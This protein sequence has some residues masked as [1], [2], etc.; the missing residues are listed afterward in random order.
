MQPGAG[1]G[2]GALQRRPL[3]R[4][5]FLADVVE[6]RRRILGLGGADGDGNRLQILQLVLAGEIAS[7]LRYKARV[8]NAAN[9]AGR[10]VADEF[11]K[12]AE[13][14]LD[15][16]DR[17]GDRIAHLGGTPD[18]GPDW[19]L[20]RRAISPA[21]DGHPSKV[22]R[23]ALCAERVLLACYYGAMHK[24]PENDEVSK[25]L[26]AGIVEGE[27]RQVMSLRDLIRRV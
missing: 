19:L 15:H 13:E 4:S 5:P 26:M 20:S 21:A 1:A 3:G 8:N 2:D 14:E 12:Y 16:A 24:L 9:G 6:V 17:I 11:D 23:E 27:R 25:M 7:L 10:L 18:F 22:V